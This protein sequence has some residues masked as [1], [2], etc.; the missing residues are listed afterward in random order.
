LKY[1]PNVVLWPWR[2]NMDHGF[3][4]DFPET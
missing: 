3:M 4:E 1:S 2:Q